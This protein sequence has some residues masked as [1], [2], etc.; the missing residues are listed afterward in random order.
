MWISKYMAHFIQHIKSYLAFILIIIIFQPAIAQSNTDVQ[1]ANEYYVQGEFEKARDI[2]GKLSKQR[3]FLSLIHTNYLS[4]LI[5]TKDY[6]EA[7]KY[8]KRVLKYYP[9]NVM[10]RVDYAILFKETGD[11]AKYD[12][13]IFALIDDVFFD[14]HR[15][16]VAA[17]NMVRKQ[18][19]EKAL[20]LYNKVRRENDDKYSY[21][22]EMANIHRIMG[23][24]D[25]MVEEYLNFTEG[26]PNNIGYVKNV[27]QNFLTEPDDLENLEL[28]LIE[29]TQKRPNETIYNELLIWVNLQMKNFSGAFIQAK[30]LDRRRDEG[31][32][33]VLDI[34]MIALENE[35]YDDAIGIFKYVIDR[36][37]NTPNYYLARRM[38]I[39]A[40][41]E[42]VKTTYPVDQQQI[43]SLAADYQLLF[44]E[45]NKSYHGLE[46]LRSKALL[47][48][49]YLDEKEEAIKILKQL[50]S[51]VR[52]SRKFV[53]TCKL[54][55]GDIYLL[56]DQPWESTLLYSQVEKE[57]EDSPLAYQAKLKNARL[58]YFNGDFA[59]AKS[60][61]DILKIATTREIS[62]DAIALSL[63]INDNTF[64]DTTDLAMQEFANV[65]LLVYQNKIDSATLRLNNMLEN[66]NG[67]N[68]TDEIWWTLAKIY[69]QQGQFEEAIKTLEKISTNY[70]YDILADDAA[71]QIA[72]I[73]EIDLKNYEKAM[74]LYAAFLR[75]YP[76]SLFVAE[77]RKRFRK[78]RG[79]F[80]N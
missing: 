26:N 36:Y 50:I 51:D 37:P 1:L 31:G 64:L 76:G 16:R 32:S 53:S 30:A 43:R 40:K 66:F 48:A 45:S 4:L 47:H 3:Q 33:E 59:L 14:R 65:E 19:P 10:Y 25:L 56:A 15:M 52:V 27:L 60:H 20:L 21:A 49:F 80:I 24:K 17:Q 75:D 39:K 9:D 57:N 7:E 63:L 62:N 28:K 44:D 5:T 23:N 72:E 12:K 79:D 73:Y 71:Y 41:E 2:Y 68:L 42:K 13:E 8:L 35:S 74:D 70:S 22:L 6:S 29:K 55:L 34:G 78:L 54:D 67:H 77:S 46:A 58:N 18:I 11:I 69:R 38:S 61:L